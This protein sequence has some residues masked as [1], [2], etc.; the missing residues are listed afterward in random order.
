MAD[1]QFVCSSNALRAVV[2]TARRVAVSKATVLLTGETGSGKEVLAR[3][4]HTASRRKGQFVPV[5]CA[6]IPKDLFEA[7]MFGSKRGSYSSSVRDTVG[8]VEAAAEGTLYLDEVGDLDIKHQAKL[9]RLLENNEYRAVGET[10]LS[11]STARVV[12]STNLD[13]TQMIATGD[14]RADLL[15]RLSQFSL[16]VPPLRERTGEIDELTKLYL[17]MASVELNYETPPVLLPGVLE[18]L[19]A[20]TWP[21]NVRELKN[22][23]YRLALFADEGKVTLETLDEAGF[24]DAKLCEAYAPR[25]SRPNRRLSVLQK[26]EKKVIEE[27]LRKFSGNITATSEYLGVSRQTVYLRLDEYDIPYNKDEKL[28]VPPVSVKVNGS[29]TVELPGVIK[30]TIDRNV[31]LPS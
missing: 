19:E 16:T 23:V 2:K 6:A 4:I 28:F 14:F 13:V 3:L 30:S 20:H 29:T 10:K 24:K 1:T 25:E 17:R 21:G 31:P 11:E 9:L 7:E 8:L 5:N 27:A 22:L 26:A 12:A 18:K 15:F